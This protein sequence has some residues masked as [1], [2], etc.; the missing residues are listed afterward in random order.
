MRWRASICCARRAANNPEA[1]PARP[2]ALSLTSRNIFLRATWRATCCVRH[3]G[4]VDGIPALHGRSL[5]RRLLRVLRPIPAASADDAPSR[6]PAS[7]WSVLGRWDGSHVHSGTA[8][9]VRYQLC[10]C[11]LATST[12]QAFL[13][14]SRPTTLT[15]PGVL[16]AEARM[17]AA[18]QPRSARFELV[19]SLEE[20]SAAGFS[21]SGGVLSSPHSSRA[22][23][24]APRPSSRP[25]SLPT[26]P[27]EIWVSAA[28]GG[29][30]HPA[31]RPIR[32]NRR[33]S[34]DRTRYP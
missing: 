12:P 15:G 34:P 30:A 1:H 27:Q 4:P 26:K 25:G 16:R 22:P 13:V 17:R 14:A 21:R 18:A 31:T 10:P 20:R 33:S 7:C 9:R 11:S 29:P 5:L 23:R 6:R 19:D 28:A 32:R 24:G 3:I 2:P 8:C